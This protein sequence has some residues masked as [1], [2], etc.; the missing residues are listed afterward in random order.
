LAFIYSDG[1]VGATTALPGITKGTKPHWF[2]STPRGAH[3]LSKRTEMYLTGVDQR[4]T[5]DAI[6]AAMDNV[7][8]PTGTGAQSPIAVVAGMRHKF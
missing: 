1:S 7:G 5:G 2:Q 6:V 3:S 8:G 4:A